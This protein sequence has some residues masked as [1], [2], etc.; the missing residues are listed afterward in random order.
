M[1]R[2]EVERGEGIAGRGKGF[3]VQTTSEMKEGL[4]LVGLTG[5]SM[6]R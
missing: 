2:V 4:F 1:S 6:V 5:K 3:G